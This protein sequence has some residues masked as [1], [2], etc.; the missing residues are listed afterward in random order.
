MQKKGS[1]ADYIKFA[2]QIITTIAIHPNS[3]KPSIALVKSLFGL[4][5]NPLDE[6]YAKPMKQNSLGEL[7]QPT[8]QEKDIQTLKQE[9]PQVSAEIIDS[10]ETVKKDS[11]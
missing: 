6:I 3:M 4:G 1:L 2:A 10:K 8:A 5:P 11:L 9:Q 7:T